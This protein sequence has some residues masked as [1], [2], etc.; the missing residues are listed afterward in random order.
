MEL[1][2]AFYIISII[3]MLLVILIL[4]AMVISVFVIRNKV[5]EIQD[6]IESIMSMGAR[7]G[8]IAAV[9]TRFYGVFRK[10]R[11]LRG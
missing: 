4:I 2:T 1:Q 6:R 10:V 3:F 7:L 5:H 11:K 9:A 8:G